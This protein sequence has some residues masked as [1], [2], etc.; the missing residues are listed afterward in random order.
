MTPSPFDRVMVHR[1]TLKQPCGF[2]DAFGSGAASGAFF[3]YIVGIFR[4]ETYRYAPLQNTSQR[5]WS[6]GSRDVEFVLENLAS[7]CG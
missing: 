2:G 4:Y 7:E 3:Y 5:R 1:F 6:F